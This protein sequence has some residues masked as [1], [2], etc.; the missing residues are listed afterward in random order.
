V[1][2]F[3]VGLDGNIPQPGYIIAVADEMLAAKSTVAVLSEVDGCVIT[4]DRKTEAKAG[5]RLLLN[6]PSGDARRTIESVDGHVV[7]VTAEYAERPET[8][9][10]WAIESDSLRVSNI[11]LW[12]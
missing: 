3:S 9:C 8:E 10:V 5:D 4:L 1:V 2:T 7:T 6:L 11:R 12:C